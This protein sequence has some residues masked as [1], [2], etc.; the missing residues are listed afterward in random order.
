MLNQ[1]WISC[2]G[3][4][5]CAITDNVIEGKATSTGVIF[6][7]GFSQT[8]AGAYGIFSQICEKIEANIPILRFD[9]MGFGDS[10]GE[11]CEVDMHSMIS[12]TEK[13]TQWFVNKTGCR[14]VIYIG[15]GIGNYIATIMVEKNPYNEAILI[16][17]Q[18]TALDKEERYKDI[19]SKIELT[20]HDIDTGELGIWNEK[21]DDFF[22]IL[23]G[24]MNR[25]KGITV[26]TD[27]L[28]EI[29]K[30]DIGEYCS[31]PKNISILNN[32]SIEVAGIL[33]NKLNDFE[34]NDVL[35]L[36]MLERER[37]IKC[38]CKYVC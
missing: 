14:K 31:Y 20:K 26:K 16:M 13:M 23:G 33:I 21:M 30:F 17:P 28:K 25:S 27:F 19:I 35:L 3:K 29:V 18:L 38:I 9:Y 5:I 22:A 37:V 24:R 12:N 34:L 8:K 7:H 32:G 10:E 4:N 1:Q 36:D 11:T 2:Q 15:H 6:L